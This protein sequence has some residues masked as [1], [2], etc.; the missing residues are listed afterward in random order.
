M[1]SIE[2]TPDY[3]IEEGYE[4]VRDS[5]EVQN[6]LNIILWL[7]EDIVWEEVELA[8]VYHIEDMEPNKAKAE[9]DKWVWYFLRHGEELQDSMWVD[10]EYIGTVEELEAYFKSMDMLNDEQ[11]EA[12][13]GPIEESLSGIQEVDTDIV[14]SGVRYQVMALAEEIRAEGY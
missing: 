2:K 10:M 7:A 11:M 4:N 1:D 6:N 9:S 5:V 3:L 14:L 8:L 12:E 13:Y